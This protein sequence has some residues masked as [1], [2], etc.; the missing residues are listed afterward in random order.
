[1]LFLLALVPPC[2]CRA[3]GLDA[4]PANSILLRLELIALRKPP[5]P[6]APGEREAPLKPTTPADP[7]EARKPSTGF[8]MQPA[9]TKRTAA[10]VKPIGRPVKPYAISHRFEPPRLFFFC[11]LC[12]PS[13]FLPPSPLGEAKQAHFYEPSV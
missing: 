3:A 1:L 10:D 12:A 11:A 9:A 5:T 13:L 7:G 4:S 8:E 2:C 6:T